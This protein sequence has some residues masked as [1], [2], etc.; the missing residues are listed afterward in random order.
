ME[1]IFDELKQHVVKKVDEFENINHSYMLVYYNNN[2]IS[3]NNIACIIIITNPSFY[4]RI[5]GGI[6]YTEKNFSSSSR[7]L[8]ELYL[9]DKKMNLNDINSIKNHI[10]SDSNI[11][12]NIEIVSDIGKN[13]YRI[14]KN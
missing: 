10:L 7:C 5:N 3:D 6:L 13:N 14:R 12:N 1:F 4:K 11:Y 8:N 9:M 2:K